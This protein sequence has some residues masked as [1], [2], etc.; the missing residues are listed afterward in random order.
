[1]KILAW[2]AVKKM[3]VCVHAVVTNHIYSSIY[4]LYKNVLIKNISTTSGAYYDQ[5]LL[6]ANQITRNISIL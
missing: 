5:N 6:S 2:M 4:M 1:M 3:H